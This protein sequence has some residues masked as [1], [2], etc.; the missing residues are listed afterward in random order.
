MCK[1][2]W[3]LG[4]PEE[5]VKLVEA[6]CLSPIPNSQRDEHSPL[7]SISQHYCIVTVLYDVSDN[8]IIDMCN[9]ECQWKNEM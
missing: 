2:C 7:F 4:C 9:I 8:L 3:D 5:P 1:K 6:S